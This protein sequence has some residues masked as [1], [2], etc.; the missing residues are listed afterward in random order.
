[1]GSAVIE[2]LREPILQC[3]AKWDSLIGSILALTPLERWE[4]LRRF[5]SY[6]ITTER[7]FVST[8]V[9]A[10]AVLTVALFVVT[11]HRRSKERRISDRLFVEYAE[12]RGLSERERQVL[13]GIAAQAGLKR[14]DSIFTLGNAFDRGAAKMIKESLARGQTTEE[15]EQLK[16]ELSFL[17]EKLGFQN[18]SVTAVKPRKL[19]SRQIP[20]GKKLHIARRAGPSSDSIESTV[21]ENNDAEL[22]VKLIRPVKITFGEIWCVRYYFGNSVW[23]FDTSV[24]SCDGNILVLN[25]SNDVRFINRRRFLRVPVSKPAFI[26]RFPFVRTFVANGDKSMK[27]FKMYRSST[28]AP[29]SAWGPP[30]FVPAVITEL[31]GPGLR[32]EAQ[33]EIKVGERV[34]VVFR[35]D[36]EREEDLIPARQATKVTTSKIVENIG[37]VR[38]TKA[39]QN[40][41][42]IAVELTGLRDSDVNELIRATNAASVRA[43][44]EGQDIPGSVNTEGRVP[45]PAAVQENPILR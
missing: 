8:G 10:I 9:A 12:K 6:S 17:R 40:G 34:L 27:S 36:E 4:A 2:G 38:H 29:E 13:L 14:C 43:G 41:L 21:T 22:V 3:V 7:W 23:E 15:S 26:A 39:I 35:L 5:N 44:V 45:E 28:S 18:Q 30:K 16:T 42:S 33:L 24:V 1:M 37:E 25:H 20:T 32:I 11:L 31:A 19:N